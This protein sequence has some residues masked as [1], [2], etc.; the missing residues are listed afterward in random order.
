VLDE[1]DSEEVKLQKALQYTGIPMVEEALQEYLTNYAVVQKMEYTFENLKELEEYQATER[2][3]FKKDLKYT[4]S[5]MESLHVNTETTAE[6]IK[7]LEDEKSK[8][9]QENSQITDKKKL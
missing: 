8:I 3:G 5:R 2:D 6:Q 7:I 4:Q 9:E 1:S